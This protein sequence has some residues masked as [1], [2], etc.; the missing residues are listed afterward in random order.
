MIK[1]IIH[2]T[3]H[4]HATGSQ[5]KYSRF[6][7]FEMEGAIVNIV[8]EQKYS[9]KTLAELEGEVK[10]WSKISIGTN[11]HYKGNHLLCSKKFL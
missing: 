9:M 3:I 11:L 6:R 8:P 7:P 2:L 5:S 4:A 10:T 1:L